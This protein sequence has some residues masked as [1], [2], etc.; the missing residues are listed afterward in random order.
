MEQ[1]ALASPT[2][3]RAFLM[4]IGAGQKTAFLSFLTRH[5]ARRCP[6][7]PGMTADTPTTD[8]RRYC[9]R[10][11]EKSASDDVLAGKAAR[12][13]DISAQIQ[14][15]L[16]RNQ[17]LN[18]LHCARRRACRRVPPHLQRILPPGTILP[19]WVPTI[20]RDRRH[21]ARTGRLRRRWSC[22]ICC[23]VCCLDL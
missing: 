6:V 3:N 17:P 19:S 9:F 13:T 1:A 8:H 10:L 22:N 11:A 15:A 7:M 18:A 23:H 16:P 21:F 2:T 5:R 12:E 14:D 20:S 4:T